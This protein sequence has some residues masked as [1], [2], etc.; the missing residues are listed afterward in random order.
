M[1]LAGKGSLAGEHGGGNLIKEDDLGRSTV[2]TEKGCALSKLT[3]RI[4]VGG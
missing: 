4:E 1:H 3:N 2:S